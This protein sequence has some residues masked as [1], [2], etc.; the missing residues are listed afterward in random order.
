MDVH[1]YIG[2]IQPQDNVVFVFGSNPI[3]IN[4][5][6]QT[7]AGGAALVAHLQFGVEQGE[8]MANCLSKSGKA[9]GLVTVTAPG[10]K[11]SVNEVEL[12]NNISILY[13]TAKEQPDKLFCVAYR[14]WVTKSLN[15]YYGYELFGMFYMVAQQEGGFPENIVLSQ[16]WMKKCVNP[17][18]AINFEKQQVLSL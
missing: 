10:C 16:E 13:K 17:I 4:G 11:R 5:N 12:C 15:G 14:N 6:S 7:G 9:Y 3:G 2:D 8:K 1:Y 18:L